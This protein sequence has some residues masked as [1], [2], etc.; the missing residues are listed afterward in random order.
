AVA[1]VAP[2]D[3]QCP[4]LVYCDPLKLESPVVR[5]IVGGRW[6]GI[7]VMAVTRGVHAR[8]LRGIDEAGGREVAATGNVTVVGWGVDRY[9]HWHGSPLLI[10]ESLQGFNNDPAEQHLAL[11][12]VEPQPASG[13]ELSRVG[14]AFFLPEQLPGRI[15]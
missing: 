12:A 11:E 7:S 4:P 2:L 10:L 8:S 5:G 15:Q 14:L 3:R 6:D 13:R 9:G 1:S